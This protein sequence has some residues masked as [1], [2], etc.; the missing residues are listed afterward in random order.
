MYPGLERER[1]SG[2]HGHGFRAFYHLLRLCD[3]IVFIGF[4]FRDDDVMHIVLNALAERRER[5]KVLIVDNSLTAPNVAS[6]LEEAERRSSFP[7]RTPKEGSIKGMKLRFGIDA[8]F[9][10]AILNECNALL[11]KGNNR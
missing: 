1:G 5:L 11:R 10:D 7:A 9:D 6:C 8:G 4:S 2:P 3:L